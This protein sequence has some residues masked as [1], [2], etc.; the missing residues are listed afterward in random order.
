MKWSEYKI[1]EIKFGDKNYP[2]LLNTILK[3]PNQLYYRGELGKSVFKKSLA[4]VGSR[5]MTSYGKRSLEKILP[6]IIEN[7]VT[8]VSG[9]MYGVDTLAHNMTVEMKGKTIAVFGCGLNTCYP[10][11]NTKLYTKVLQNKGV[12]FSEYKSDLKPKPW[13]YVQRNRIVSGL[14]TLG[15]L[16]IEAGKGSGSLV[17][18]NLATQQRKQVY[19]LPGPIDSSNSQGTNMLIKSGDAKLVTD[20]SDILNIS[21]LMPQKNAE[22]KGLESQIYKLIQREPLTT[23]EIALYLNKGIVEIM[24]TVTSL[25][26]RGFVKDEAGRITLSK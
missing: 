9:F 1:K 8:I 22:L 16:V 19:A 7:G 24:T 21:T 5:R 17:T 11:E 23:D 26:M 14:S 6:P 2:N 3:P 18:A 4:V 15:V 25:S 20:A 13:M 10:P 12:I